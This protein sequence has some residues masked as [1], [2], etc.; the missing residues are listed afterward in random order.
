[1]SARLRFQGQ[2]R[3]VISH[4]RPVDLDR[5]SDLTVAGI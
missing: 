3:A 2:L 4:G 5:M 1:M